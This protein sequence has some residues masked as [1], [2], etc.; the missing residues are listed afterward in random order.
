MSLFV[1][2]VQHE[3]KEPM[4]L[5][6]FYFSVFIADDVDYNG[7]LLRTLRTFSYLSNL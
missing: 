3:A 6:T 1:W 7:N 4:N 5:R 2:G